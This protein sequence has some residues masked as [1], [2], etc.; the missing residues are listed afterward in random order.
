MYYHNKTDVSHGKPPTRQE[1][2]IH[3]D[4]TVGEFRRMLV[5]WVVKQYETITS[6]LPNHIGHL[7]IPASC[8]WIDF[9]PPTVPP[10]AP[11]SNHFPPRTATGRFL[12]NFSVTSWS[13]LPSFHY[14]NNTSWLA[15]SNRAIQLNEM[16]L[17]NNAMG[18][19]LALIPYKNRGNPRCLLAR[20][21]RELVTMVFRQWMH[22]G[23]G[24]VPP[25]PPPVMIVT[26]QM[27]NIRTHDTLSLTV[28][29]PVSLSPIPAWLVGLDPMIVDGFTQVLAEH[30]NGPVP[31]GG[32]PENHGQ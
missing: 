1:M 4:I 25:V 29:W 15:L 20:L 18:R 12:G 8:V 26:R 5:H 27:V 9:V 28:E 16:Y 3:P 23:G 22:A 24:F 19:L 32:Q 10:S 7:P 31:H 11:L 17:H 6:G 14:Q 2:S 13:G 21:P 30:H